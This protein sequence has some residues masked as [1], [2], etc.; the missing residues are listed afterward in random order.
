MKTITFLNNKGGVGKTATITTVG[1]ILATVHRKKVLIVD[2]D[3][4]ANTSQ[5]FGSEGTTEKCSL[6]DIIEEKVYP[7]ENTVE[8]LLKDS[9]KD[10]YDCIYETAYEGLHIVPSFITLSNVENQLLGNVSE[11]QQFRLYRQLEKVADDYDYCLIDCGPSVSLLNINALAASDV[12]YIPAKCDKNSRVGIANILRIVETVQGF[13]Q[14]GLEFG[15]CFLVQYD[16]RKKICR[17]AYADCQDALGDKFL[18]VT[19]PTNTKVEQTSTQQKP[20]YL[21]DPKGKATEK[22]MELTKYIM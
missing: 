1:H 17:E 13:S 10:V 16:E 12:V 6:R 21:L 7:T 15:G 20:L 9:Q 3:P 8:D 2:M 5:L 11:P 19:I 4:Q 14:K 22:Y 18:P